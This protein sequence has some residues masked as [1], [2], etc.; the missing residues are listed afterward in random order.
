MLKT[1]A[2]VGAGPSGLAAIKELKEA[3]FEVTAFDRSASVGG[4]WSLAPNRGVWKE[5]CLNINRRLMS[6]SDFEWK[7]SCY[8]GHEQA[9][10][11][12]FPHCTEAKQYLE[13][14]AKHFDIMSC[15]QLETEV[16]SIEQSDNKGWKIVTQTAG[17]TTT[18]THEFDGLIICSGVYG[19]PSNPLKEIFSS[20]S[21]K[22]IH[23]QEFST[24]EGYEGKRVL[25]IGSSIS[26]SEIAGA[27]VDGGKCQSLVNSIRQVRYHMD[28][29]NEK[30]QKPG[31][32]L[33]FNR[34]PV[35]LGKVL[36][37]SITTKGLKAT[38]LDLWPDQLT[39]AED[40]IEPD[41]DVRVASICIDRH[42]VQ[43]AKAGKIRVKPCPVASVKGSQ[44]T[45]EDGTKEDFDVVIMATGYDIDLAFLPSEVREKVLFTNTITGKQDLALYKF[46]LTP[47]FEN[48]AFCGVIYIVGPH[49]PT[50]EMQAR[51]IAAIFSGKM[52]RPSKEQLE[53]SIE[54]SKLHRSSCPLNAFDVY[55]VFCDSVGDE[56]GVTPTFSECIW[57]PKKLLL[58]PNYSC[59]YR[60][61]PKIEG[62]EKAN[63]CRKLFDEYMSN[64]LVAK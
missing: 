10:A 58:G 29:V 13:D 41:D 43:Y 63:Q 61:N 36:P 18:T 2:V 62:E 45:F 42:Y 26:A 20:F 34:L 15:I 38:I 28:I 21:G 47:Q 14:Y 57:N 51:Y 52:P 30:H 16:L 55:P 1:F 5:L 37:E 40:G 60:R 54:Q 32:D 17:K 56:L 9:Y 53:A 8:Q 59:N 11:G 25:V 6:F 27:L 39:Q 19:K 7:E 12:V 50:A 23:S 22:V 31:G 44:V 46:M 33:I 48:L 3:G 35:W 64:P 4:R 24:Y 49:F